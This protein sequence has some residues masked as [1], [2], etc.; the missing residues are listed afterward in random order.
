ML[1]DIS[2]YFKFRKLY[3]FVC[4]TTRLYVSIFNWRY[5]ADLILSKY[6][7]SLMR[8]MFSTGW[9]TTLNCLVTEYHL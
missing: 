8:K 4:K 9:P 7:S 5:E 3:K 1:L 6:S 2:Q